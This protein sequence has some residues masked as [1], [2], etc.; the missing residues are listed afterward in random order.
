MFTHAKNL[1]S[2]YD[3]WPS[4]QMLYPAV[5][6]LIVGLFIGVFISYNGFLKPDAFAGEYIHFGR[7]RPVHVTTV[8]LL[9]LLSANLGLMY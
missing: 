4:K 8:T 5:F 6:F 3:D 9:W 2:A 1:H 7:V